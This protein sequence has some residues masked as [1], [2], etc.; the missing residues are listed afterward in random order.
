M[1]FHSL[2]VCAFGPFAGTQTVNFDALSSDG[3]FLLRGQTGSGK[4]SVL[5]AITFAL[6][7]NVP[8]ERRPE[9]LKSQHAPMERKPY[10]EL[11]FS[12]GEDRLWVRRE[13]SYYRPAK[14]RGA[15]P[16][17][18]SQALYI[19]RLHHGEWKPLPV[20]KIDEGGAELASILG[21]SMSEFTKVIMLPQG[22]FAQLLHAT[23]EERRRILEQLFDIGIYDRLEGYL[24]EHKKESESHLK[25][26]DSRIAAHTNQLISAAA[27]LLRDDM[28]ATEAQSPEELIEPL[29]SRA[30]KGHQRLRAAEAQAQQAAEHAAQELDL[31]TTRH[32]Q[33]TY[34]AEHTEQRRIHEQAR[35]EAVQ[36]EHL[37]AEHQAAE[38]VHQWL[39][40][41]DREANA[42]QQQEAMAVS[43]EQ[44]AQVL[45]Q[46]QSEVIADTLEAAAEELGQLHARLTDPE[47]RGLDERY[48]E[49]GAAAQSAEQG[50]AEAERQAHTL[51]SQVASAQE[52]LQQQQDQIVSPEQTDREVEA[53]QATVRAAQ[54]RM[55]QVADRDATAS[56]VEELGRQ[57]EEAQ[58]R[59]DR[60]EKDYRRTSAAYLQSLAQELAENLSDGEPCLVCG[61]TEHPEPLK[62]DTET[63][64]KEDLNAV[65]EALQQARLTR[66]SIADRQLS[67]ETKL[68]GIHS[69]LSADA[70]LSADEAREA[71]AASLQQCRDATQRRRQ[72]R[73]LTDQVQEI[74]ERLVTLRQEQTTAEHTASRRAADAH[75]ISEE[76]QTLRQRLTHL[77]GQHSSIADRVAA[78]NQWQQ[79]FKCAQKARQ[80]A[81]NA[82]AAAQRSAEE[83]DEH[84]NASP[85]ADRHAV[86][87]ARLPEETLQRL[88]Q[89]VTTFADGE[90]RLRFE[91]ELEDVTAGRRRS[92]QGEKLPSQ[93][94]LDDAASRAHQARDAL[95]HVHQQLA[96]YKAESKAVE[97]AAADLEKVLRSR[98]DQ[99]VE[100][101]LRAELADAVRAQGGDNDKG[102][103]LTTYV[104]A[105]RLERVTEAAT[106][107][108]I[109][110]TDG[111]YQLLLD[112]ERTG[113]GQ[114]L[115]GLD[116][117]VYDEYAEQERPAESLSG[118]E[119]FMASLSLALGLAEVVQS[120]SGGVGL[121]SLFIDEGFGSLDD[122]TLES[123][124][125]ALHT[126]QGEG[127]RIG[128]VSH[129]SE[130]HQQIPVQLKVTKTNSGSTLDLIGVS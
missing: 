6:Y 116:L 74:R 52:T 115:R 109:A 90:K 23:N 58:T 114:R 11:E 69:A 108:L 55:E 110:M 62:R 24:W 20:H 64:T 1:K 21:L 67:A 88:S 96:Q 47:A 123:V 92:E 39:V 4:T 112:P 100:A 75:R 46:D 29:L 63:V 87:S 37:L 77:R 73:E 89:Q 12:T 98:Q 70:H 41:A 44:E 18:E 26:L 49:L 125:S 59:Q 13:A 61:S 107:H 43:A 117:K 14:R 10:V 9:G 81:E 68:Q 45:L 53:A 78:L 71:Y 42:A 84:I 34:W 25:E 66:G 76:A 3:L 119:T 79:V 5:D 28:P 113:T 15:A 80:E 129:V 33:L 128:V 50:A 7:G 40:R 65:T 121:D 17:R 31:L 32:R 27:A 57:A 103:R 56:Q 54:A 48:T 19:K 85:F 83:A 22:S 127:R 36:A 99:A 94:D 86:I 8:G 51:S 97:R 95:E 16:Q 72:Q 104:L 93:K 38:A 106:R 111:R 122:H 101:H 82:A 30:E 120:E 2:T 35:P 118:G 126:L 102:M 105:A 91:A 130:M 60:A 124:M